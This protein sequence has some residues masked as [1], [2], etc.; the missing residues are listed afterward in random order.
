MGFWDRFRRGGDAQAPAAPAQAATAAPGAAAAAPEVPA[1]RPDWDGGWRE[2]APP[3]VTIARSTPAVSDGMRFRSGLAAWQNPTLTSGLGHGL[4]PSAPAG[5]IHGVARPATGPR[6]STVEGGGPL[7]LRA[8][9][10]PEADGEPGPATT[11]HGPEHP[12][13]RR[14]VTAPV[15]ERAANSGP[16]ATAPVRRADSGAPM[17]AGTD[18]LV[19]SRSTGTDRAPGTPTSS[20]TPRRT[21][22]APESV[23]EG[24]PASTAPVLGAGSGAPDALTVSRPTPDATGSGATTAGTDPLVVSR[25]TAADAASGTPTSS[26]S[27]GRAASVPEGGP[28]SGPTRI[29]PVLGADSGASDPLVVSRSTGTDAASGTPTSSATP[30]RA[31]SVPEGGPESGPTRTA[32]VL[33]AGSG[34]SDALM[35]SRRTASAPERG[36]GAPDALTVARRATDAGGS[37]SATAATDP[38]VVSRRTGAESGTGAAATTHATTGAPENARTVT[39]G[40]SA[41]RNGDVV[42]PT[43]ASARP[44]TSASVPSTRPVNP[45]TSAA[46]GRPATPGA[47]GDSATPSASAA[48]AGPSGEA[49]TLGSGSGMP[50]VLR[51]AEPAAPGRSD[52]N[53]PATLP[54]VGSRPD[55]SGAPAATATGRPSAHPRPTRPAPVRPRPVGTSLVVARRPAVPPRVLAA[56]P[57]RAPATTAD[58]A[59]GPKPAPPGRAD[60]SPRTPAARPGLGEP[61]AELPV[62]ARRADPANTTAP[63]PARPSEAPP[64]PVMRRMT[65]TDTTTGPRPTTRS[66]LG[67]PLRELPPTATPAAPLLGG[68]APT[69]RSE[70]RPAAPA[71]RTPVQR[72]VANPG[73]APAVS[74]GPSQR[75]SDPPLPPL[76]VVPVARAA[77]RTAGPAGSAAPSG[78]APATA[79]QPSRRLLADRPLVVGT[80]V[81]EGFSAQPAPAHASGAAPRPVVAATWRRAP[82]PA[83]PPAPAPVQRAASRP[84]AS[85][86]PRTSPSAHQGGSGGD[87]TTPRRGPLA[88]LRPT[89]AAGSRSGGAA[90]VLRTGATPPA[91]PTPAHAP[92]HAPAHAPVQ[93]ATATPPAPGPVSPDDA[94]PVVP[95]V[96]LDPAPARTAAASVQ[97]TASPLPMPFTRGT[98]PG[99]G[100]EPSPP[101]VVPAP[102]ANR[103]QAR[104]VQR[105]AQEGLGGVPV[106]PVPRATPP[107]ATQ[108]TSS[109]PPAAAATSTP[110]SSPR[111]PEIEELAR[112]LIDPV[113]R[114]L[115]AEM[116]R[117]RERTGRPYDNRR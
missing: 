22:S 111:G 68:P 12:V 23:P 83:A 62:T 112:Q 71:G 81:P 106:T 110:A 9:R 79:V 51:R 57:P 92:T 93:R 46:P 117:G 82:A 42:R 16:S 99:L 94:P 28:E 90:P 88:R 18:P 7:L 66:G 33:G 49:Q 15:A 107:S 29:A 53:G 58:R 10:D 61:L 103:L 55:A 96:R 91:S 80:G 54:V 40:A 35:V 52:A 26:A 100:A 47:R 31:A 37:G 21:A 34:A 102:A 78:D 6:T 5:L 114:L 86:P 32:P 104:A 72:D 43:N 60:R 84:D 48:G 20:A 24:G 13:Q 39:P 109:A 50:T 113:A 108:P 64:L 44:D 8:V 76:P 105:M 19:V 41:T 98:G 70:R 75:P 116:R 63:A 3:S 85:R 36:S 89:K 17:T 2:V 56:V 65:E 95:R 30:G 4:M 77:E 59:P 14:T 27:P 87:P 69:A 73:S 67:A 115:R 25:S 97:R 38:L 11:P 1:G 45:D 74:S 101:P